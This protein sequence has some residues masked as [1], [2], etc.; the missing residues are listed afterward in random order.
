M[1]SLK[2][3]YNKIANIWGE[4]VAQ[5][6]T[7]TYEIPDEEIQRINNDNHNECDF[8]S[9]T[10]DELMARFKTFP[11][12]KF[13][14]DSNFKNNV[15]NIELTNEKLI[16]LVAEFVIKAKS[17]VPEYIPGPDEKKKKRSKGL[18]FS[19]VPSFTSERYAESK[20]SVHQPTTYE[21]QEKCRPSVVMPVSQFTLKD[22][23]DGFR[24]Y[25][26]KTDLF[27]ISKKLLS[28]LTDYQKTL[29]INSFNSSVDHEFQ[30]TYAFGRG[31]L[32]YKVTKLGPAD[33]LSSFREI[34]TIPTAVNHFHRILNLRLNDHVLANKYIDNTIQKA[35]VSGIKYGMPEQ[36][37]KLKSILTDATKAADKRTSAI[38][39]IDIENAF[40]SINRDHI[41]KTLRSL[42]A[43]EKY[44]N[45][46]KSFYD[47]FRFFTKTKNW[48]SN[49][50]IW[51]DGI[52]QGCPLSPQ[53]FVLSIAN[54]LENINN[55]YRNTHGYMIN[56]VPILLMAYVDD[57]CIIT[58][59]KQCLIEVYH[60][61]KEQLGQI[62]LLIGKAKS[63]F[64]LVNIDN[65]TP[66]DDITR[67]KTYKYLGMDVMDNGQVQD[68]SL[69][70][71]I[72]NSLMRVDA[73]KDITDK[74]KY[75]KEFIL[76]T[77]QRKFVAMYDMSK[78]KKFKIAKLILSFTKSW[79][80]NES[81]KIFTD[82]NDILK[83][84]NDEFIKQAIPNYI[85]DK[86][87]VNV[88]DVEQFVMDNQDLLEFNYNTTK[89]EIETP[90]IASDDSMV[91]C[92][93]TDEPTRE[94]TIPMHPLVI[95]G[96]QMN[97]RVSNTCPDTNMSTNTST[98]MSTNTS[99]IP[100]ICQPIPN[101]R[102][103]N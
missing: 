93:S 47:N 76:P 74:I 49:D 91:Q 97:A 85:Y 88:A 81:L 2:S 101:E 44:V 95:L 13:L 7:T 67:T 102:P 80:P 15:N 27:G 92:T 83:F 37:Y 17:V 10:R 70:Y 63:N 41:Y 9:L 4:S 82:I 89:E 53:L 23:N 68:K 65:D 51:G 99:T 90:G 73:A 48:V 58:K 66:I 77:I 6:V 30:P 79:S 14:V 16:S 78:S 12:Y 43:P 103:T 57:I 56:G 5:V 96:R 24:D 21:V 33:K 60:D 50:L 8:D 84:T 46:I 29:F 69:Y 38:M 87:E 42:H 45:Y 62:N 98:N 36:I 59:N 75:F 19:K 25:E 61:I 40:G 71:Q 35:G 34:I 31:V 28:E 3:L 1:E 55:K 94:I 72:Q 39:F 32:L 18:N 54:I 86:E 20:V 26:S 100:T 64:M 22:F 52:V 11:H